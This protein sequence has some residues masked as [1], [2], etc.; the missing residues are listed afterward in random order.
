MTRNYPRFGP[1]WKDGERLADTVHYLTLVDAVRIDGK[2]RQ[3]HI[4][5]LGS[6]SQSAIDL[7]TANQRGYFWH[8]VLEKLDQLNIQI[9]PEERARIEAKIAD[10]VPRLTEEEKQLGRAA[11][12]KWGSDAVFR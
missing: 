3:R 4:A 5:Y 6:V 11:A 9:L 7:D 1:H 8:N 12:Q 2:P 10:R